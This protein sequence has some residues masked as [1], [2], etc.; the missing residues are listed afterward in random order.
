[1]DEVKGFKRFTLNA[2]D[3]ISRGYSFAQKSNAKEYKAIHLFYT[4]LEDE[5][6]MVRDVFERLGVD[7]QNTLNRIK[8][9]LVIPAVNQETSTITVKPSF[10][11]EIKKILN[12]AFQVAVEMKSVYVG[13]EHI[14][15]SMFKIDS[16][17]FVADVKKA[18]IT[19]DLLKKTFQAISHASAALKPMGAPP[20]NFS[21]FTKNL[22]IDEGESDASL[23]FFCRDMNELAAKGEYME[24]I[25]RDKEIQRLLHILSRKTKNNPI[26]VG[27]A[28]V[29]KTAIVEG[30]VSRIVKG[31][32]PASF[33]DVK[34][35]S[36]DIA[37]ILSGARL[38]GDVEERI[39]SIIEEVMEDGNTILFIDE[40]HTIVGA[41]S[42]GARDSMD[43][44]NI[45]KPYLTKS[46]LSII[47]ATTYDEYSKYFETDSALSRRFQPIIVEEIDIESA[48]EIMHK[49]S[50]DFEK[51]HNVT[52]QREAIDE[53]VELSAKFIQDRYLPDKAIDVIDESAASIKIGREIAIE[54]ELSTLGERLIKIQGKK[55]KALE[56]NNLGV[57]AKYKKEEDSIVKEIEEILSGAKKVK[58]TYPKSVTST[59]V[60]EVIVNWT[61]IPI[62]ASD[63]TDKTLA[64]LEQRLSQR[65]IGQQK[66]V[67]NVSKAMQRSH[68]GLNDGNRPLASFLFLGPTGVG[69]TELAKT[70]AKELF[71]SKDLLYQVDMSEFM[72]MHSVSKLIGSPPGYVGYQEGGQLT[73]FV[74]R[75]PYSVILFDEVEKAHPDTLNL[76]LQILEE[77]A[78]TDSKGIKVS[79]KNTIII[80]TSNIGAENVAS[81]GRL[82][83]DI[84]LNDKEVELI[85]QAYSDMEVKLLEELRRSLRPEFLNRIDS[86]NVFRGLNKSD[87]LLITRNIIDD[88]IVRLVHK[89][90]VLDVSSS[91]YDYVN[92]EGYSVEYGGRNIRRKVQELVE[93]G[94]A[95]FL[96]SSNI[97]KKKKDVVRVQLKLKGGKLAFSKS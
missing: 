74:R 75:K 63:I 64:D 69:K 83:F 31:N 42:A 44:A 13:T 95:A 1:M 86:I 94:L 34:V 70:L 62:V 7:I 60:R 40:I 3:I 91:V 85:D 51:Y 71:G 89:G 32:V 66:A 10:S 57:A 59:L 4:M 14:V 5:K 56:V 61:K 19:Y 97:K 21:A 18:G 26:L 29:G 22:G 82:G 65:V 93:D 35:M 80:M 17:D 67:T 37:S 88:L 8:E 9:R 58:K 84:S 47:G 25:G 73:T 54:P 68:L 50:K 11:A 92:Q 87:C 49:I 20:M 46:D 72:E 23:P 6:S 96:I 28:G 38:R 79:F 77:G 81:D 30:L 36:L 41:G 78:L 12:D 53:A 45:L 90:I 55:E 15:L 39:T 2:R 76:L 43:I 27:D 24:V 48:K 52:I 16:I 33:L